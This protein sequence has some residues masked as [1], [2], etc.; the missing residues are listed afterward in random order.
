MLKL[1]VE[2]GALLAKRGRV[3][4]FP[5]LTLRTD[6]DGPPRYYGSTP[7]HDAAKSGSV[8]SVAYLLSQNFALEETR[9][10]SIRTPLMEAAEAGKLAVVKYLIDRGANVHAQD[11][12][13]STVAIGA[14]KSGVEDIL[15]LLFLHD[16]DLTKRGQYSQSALS[17]ALDRGHLSAAKLVLEQLDKQ[18]NQPGYGDCLGA[19]LSTAAVEG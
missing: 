9:V 3:I 14:A 16:V 5:G 15:R 6:R 4:E 1:L 10:S 19:A 11:A 13:G 7:L 18:K 17:A 12:D 2:Q 8:E